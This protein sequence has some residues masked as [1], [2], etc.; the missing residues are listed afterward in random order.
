[1][2]VFSFLPPRLGGLDMLLPLF[3]KLKQEKPGTILEVVF[4]KRQALEQLERDPFLLDT[5]SSI[6][7]R[8][9]LLYD[10]KGESC[11]SF[12]LMHV[13]LLGVLGRMFLSSKP[14]VLHHRNYGGRLIRL[15]YS[16]AHLRGGVTFGH[17]AAGLVLFKGIIKNRN[18]TV[19]PGDGYLC[20]SPDDVPLLRAQGHKRVFSIGYTRLYECWIDLVRNESGKYVGSEIDRLGMKISEEGMVTLFLASTVVDVFELDE[21]A[22]WLIDVIELLKKKY[23]KIA[24]V[25]KPHPMQDMNHLKNVLHEI[26][27]ENIGVSFL[28]HA[29]LAVS[30]KIVI[31]H[32]T[33]IIIDSLALNVP[34]IQYQCFTRHWLKRHPH[35][36]ELLELKPLWAKNKKELSVLIDKACSENFV[37]SDISVI[38]K[39]QENIGSLLDLNSVDYNG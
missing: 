21:L 29:L 23:P 11:C 13:R 3:I 4:S 2:K 22:I 8:I 17:A 16:I 15:I 35:G 25:I 32:H 1:M 37:V 10:D 33:S 7:D 18:K 24:I 26:N 27:E 34:T 19:W 14:R 6:V 31:A 36:S 20:F 12:L 5:F 39:H 28:H 9:T 30:S 38:L